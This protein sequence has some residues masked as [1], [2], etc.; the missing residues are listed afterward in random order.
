MRVA[1]RRAEGRRLGIVPRLTLSLA[2]VVVLAGT[3][4]M[5]ARE[6][7]RVMRT[8]TH[9]TRTDAPAP[10]PPQEQPRAPEPRT[11]LETSRALGAAL[12]NYQHAAEALVAKDSAANRSEFAS[13]KDALQLE[14]VELIKATPDD[15]KSALFAS[16]RVPRYL[17]QGGEFVDMA[18]R[19][20]SAQIDYIAH[21][22]SLSDEIQSSLSSAWTLFGRVIARQS[23]IQMRAETDAMRQHSERLVAGEGLDKNNADL[24]TADESRFAQLIRSNEAVLEK[25][26][27]ANWMQ[28][29]RDNFAR[30]LS[31]RHSLEALDVQYDRAAG[32]FASEGRAVAAELAAAQ[33]NLEL[34]G[35]ALALNSGTARQLASTAQGAAR[36]TVVKDTTTGG[37]ADSARLMAIVTALVMT[38]VVV[39][40]VLI[41]RGIGK[42]VKQMVN[43]ANQLASGDTNVSVA[44]GGIE[45]LDLLAQAFND[46]SSKLKSMQSARHH[47]Q[48]NLETIILERTHKLQQ[49][50]LQDP[51]TSLPNRRH[52]TALLNAAIER[53]TLDSSLLGV[54]FL[55]I[56]HFKNINDSVGHVFGDRVLMSVANR[57][58]ELTDG[59]GFVARLGGDEFTIVFEKAASVEA[60]HELGWSI[61]R[62]FQKLLSVDDRELS[63]SVSVGASIFPL[64]ESNAE[65]LLRD[66]DSALFRAKELG[67]S[68]LAVFTPELITTAAARFSI[69]QGLRLAIE[70]SEFELAYQPEINLAVGEVELVEALLRW[71]LPD[72]RI[73]RPG[74]FLAV[75]EQSGIIAEIDDWV[76]RTAVADAARWHHGQWPNVRVAINVSPRQLLDHHFVEK[77]LALV[78]ELRLPPHCIEFELTEMA[79]Q[80]GR[81]TIS[82][83]RTLRQHGFGIALDDFGTGYS[84]LTSLEE[85]PLT[86][87]KLDR[88]L[89]ARIDTSERSAAIARAI[90][91]LCDGLKLQVTAEGIERSEQ[92]G[93]FCR[94]G[95][96]TL[97]GYLLSDAL[98]F[99]EVLNAKEL[100]ANKVQDLLLSVRSATEEAVADRK[101]VT[102][103]G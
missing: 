25:S 36:T 65:A 57:L 17:E 45:E 85:L 78:R 51:L 88:S 64:H 70:R 93:W 30:L 35:A 43:A 44:R 26:Q 90:V 21:A 84:S 97:Q 27:G 92:F 9:S 55:D 15:P 2:A 16:Q 50:A 98:P 60:I 38:V 13:T 31:I 58:E 47:E 20:R 62:A 46:M 28:A 41:V 95:G 67:R 22:K 71:R 5:I 79:F 96:I 32:R 33:D 54:Y 53:A 76:L 3:A 37:D 24:L 39:I 74:E 80:T 34:A 100:L 1:I 10:Q 4:N 91:D 81:T 49:L 68:Q 102:A 52:L 40:S 18:S 94:N 7:V 23:L 72:G 101:V 8:I 87:I 86:R 89:V 82:S 59:L 61:A 83:L 75:A 63:L 11:G 6:S 99:Q 14:T 29:V 19:R 77:V 42:P 48:E 66:A 12:G 73:A 56:D 103:T 69:E